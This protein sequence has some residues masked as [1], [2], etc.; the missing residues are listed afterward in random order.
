MFRESNI[1]VLSCNKFSN[2][3][4]LL[5]NILIKERSRTLP[6]PCQEVQTRGP[7]PTGVSPGLRG[8]SNVDSPKERPN[9][10]SCRSRNLTSWHQSLVYIS[11][12][13]REGDF[14][15]GKMT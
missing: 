7:G 2:D 1:I 15:W 4:K 10:E 9:W 8:M 6:T 3:N 13:H 12:E 5:W 14:W 11:S